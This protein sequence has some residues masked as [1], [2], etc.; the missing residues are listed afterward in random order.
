MS[1]D[2]IPQVKEK[3][4][5]AQIGLSPRGKPMLNYDGSFYGLKR[6]EKDGTHIWKCM[7]KDC[8]GKLLARNDSYFLQEEHWLGEPGSVK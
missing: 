2:V 5:E 3:A 8:P 7:N 1:A 4:A 6:V